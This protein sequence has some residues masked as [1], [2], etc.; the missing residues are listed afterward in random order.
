MMKN[1]KKSKQQMTAE[2]AILYYELSPPIH[3]GT[4]SELQRD[5]E[6]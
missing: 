4:C 2:T 1:K 5:G 3:D 6:I